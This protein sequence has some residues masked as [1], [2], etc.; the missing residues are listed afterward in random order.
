M[1]RALISNAAEYTG[2]FH[3]SEGSQPAVCHLRVLWVCSTTSR[4]FQKALS[5]SEENVTLFYCA[6][7]AVLDFIT[8]L[9]INRYPQPPAP[10]TQ[11]SS[12]IPSQ[13]DWL[14]Q[15]RPASHCVISGNRWASPNSSGVYVFPSS[16]QEEKD[17][18]SL[19]KDSWSLYPVKWTRY[20]KRLW[21]C[22]MQSSQPL[23]DITAAK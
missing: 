1:V 18:S 23:V 14:Q 9:C 20:L 3:P 15:Q 16:W 11:A 13:V 19:L 21:L 10:K 12:L 4:C 8:P 7:G 6:A 2:G 5:G 17:D 22:I